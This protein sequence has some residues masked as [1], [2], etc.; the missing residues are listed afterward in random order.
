ME[1][2]RTFKWQKVI[3]T[4]QYCS[5]ESK[6]YS[7]DSIWK[8]FILNLPKSI[9]NKN[10]FEINKLPPPQHFSFQTISKIIKVFVNLYQLRY[11]VAMIQSCTFPN[12]NRETGYRRKGGRDGHCTQIG[13]RNIM[14]VGVQFSQWIKKDG[15]GMQFISLVRGKPR[16]KEEDGKKRDTHKLGH[17]TCK[18]GC[19]VFTLTKK[20]QGRDA[21][22]GSERN[23]LRKKNG[24]GIGE[25]R[26]RKHTL[27][28]YM[29]TQDPELNSQLSISIIFRHTV[30]VKPWSSLLLYYEGGG[31]VKKTTHF[32]KE[33][34]G[35]LSILKIP[36]SRW[37]ML[38]ITQCSFQISKH[39]AG[40][41]HVSNSWSF[42]I[43]FTESL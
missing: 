13:T 3:R 25:G 5:C 17:A 4:Q 12:C 36:A 33:V 7:A 43:F 8:K 18:G 21:D 35:K 27:W 1:W 23:T 15:Q 29:P 30:D 10:S 40:T 9:K 2:R 32:S 34:V 42:F 14:M 24:K 37:V 19:S 6:C 31:G 20:R 22:Q 41:K 38:V 39:I 28:S 26:G 11:C 16:R